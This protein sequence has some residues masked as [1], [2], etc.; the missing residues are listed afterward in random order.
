MFGYNIV[1]ILGFGSCENWLHIS[2]L[3]MIVNNQSWLYLLKSTEYNRKIRRK[4]CLSYWYIS[5]FSASVQVRIAAF[6]YLILKWITERLRC[7]AKFVVVGNEFCKSTT[8]FTVY[9]AS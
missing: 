9:S 5:E 1:T 6:V 4:E 8:L 2:L 3:H 7:L